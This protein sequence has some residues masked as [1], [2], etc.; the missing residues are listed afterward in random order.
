MSGYRF[1]DLVRKHHEEK[2]DMGQHNQVLFLKGS[3]KFII[4]PKWMIEEAEQGEGLAYYGLEKRDTL[5]KP[6]GDKRD[7]KGA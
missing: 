1:R 7:L 5:P 4:A 3:D 2:R 6:T